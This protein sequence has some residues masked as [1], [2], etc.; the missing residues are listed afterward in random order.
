METNE[1]RATDQQ[2]DQMN[3]IKLG[4][5]LMLLKI[6]ICCLI[7]SL[8]Y[9]VIV[10]GVWQERMSKRIWKEMNVTSLRAE[11][12]AIL[13]L[14]IAMIMIFMCLGSLIYM[15]GKMFAFHALFA[16]LFVLCLIANLA[17]LIVTI[18]ET[19]PVKKDEYA[20]KFL[21]AIQSKSN[22]SELQDLFQDICVSFAKCNISTKYIKNGIDMGF[23]G[24]I[25][26]ISFQGFS[27]MLIGC[28]LCLM[29]SIKPSSVD[30]FIAGP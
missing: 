24:N 10:N 15:C 22:M 16:L 20:V 1:E 18:V 5:Y 3:S 27:I 29:G 12:I 9:T 2:R 11:S 28:S 4:G 7:F 19:R 13:V 30:E 26:A 14:N 23:V 25:I 8:I 21:Q 17:L 6:A